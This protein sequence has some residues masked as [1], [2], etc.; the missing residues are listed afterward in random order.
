M[1]RPRRRPIHYMVSALHDGTVT[2]ALPIRKPSK[3][4]F[5]QER[6]RVDPD[7]VTIESAS[8]G[9]QYANV[10]DPGRVRFIDL[11][12]SNLNT[13]RAIRELVLPRIEEV[14]AEVRRLHARIDAMEASPRAP[15]H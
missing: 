4:Q 7:G 11:M 15:S 2:S 12:A 5:K 6:H 1:R 13:R 3:Q 8:S 14:L 9:R 10:D